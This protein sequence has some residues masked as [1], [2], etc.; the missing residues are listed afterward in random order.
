MQEISPRLTARKPNHAVGAS[1]PPMQLFNDRVRLV[2]VSPNGAP[3]CFS[4]TVNDRLMVLSSRV[5]LLD[6][7]RALLAEGA[8]ANSWVIMRHA[9]SNIDAMRAKLGIAA[10][11]TVEDDRLGR[12]NFRRWRGLRSAGGGSPIA[13]EAAA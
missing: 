12:P 10:K 11:S 3:G 6:A 2:V 4:A 13:P 8:D 7:C 1:Q 5:P 9:G